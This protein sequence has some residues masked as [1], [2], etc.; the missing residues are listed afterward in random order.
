MTHWPSG[1]RHTLSTKSYS[2]R[3]SQYPVNCPN[4]GSLVVAVWRDHTAGEIMGGMKPKMVGGGG[5][6]VMN[7][8]SSIG[9]MRNVPC[10]PRRCECTCR[11]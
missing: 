10:G 6:R 7:I 4:S 5:Q 1:V 3:S 2:A 9:I 11:P 8:S